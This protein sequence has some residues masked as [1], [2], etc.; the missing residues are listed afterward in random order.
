MGKIT[1]MIKRLLSKLKGGRGA[2]SGNS[3]R[4]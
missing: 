1:N 2:S 4:S 3:Q